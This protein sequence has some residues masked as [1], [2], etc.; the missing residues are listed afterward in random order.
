MTTTAADIYDALGRHDIAD[1][2]RWS[3]NFRGEGPLDHESAVRLLEDHANLEDQIEWL[4]GLLCKRCADKWE[5][6]HG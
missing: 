4:E 5:R 2:L 6:S 3:E 1:A